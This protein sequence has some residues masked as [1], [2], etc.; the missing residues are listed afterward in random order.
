MSS[1]DASRIVQCNLGIFGSFRL[2]SIKNGCGFPRT[3]CSVT[4]FQFDFVMMQ[5]LLQERVM[6]F[7]GRDKLRRE[8]DIHSPVKNLS[9]LK[10]TP[11]LNNGEQREQISVKLL[12]YLMH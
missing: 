2:L 6:P 8:R 9:F 5:L 12:N 4:C 7:I 11:C 3:L 1:G 10:M